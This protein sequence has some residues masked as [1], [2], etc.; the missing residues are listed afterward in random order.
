MGGCVT[1]SSKDRGSAE[2]DERKD[3]NQETTELHASQAS[4]SITTFKSTR[5][6]LAKFYLKFPRINKAYKH[7]FNGWCEAIGKTPSNVASAREIFNF[8]GPADKASEALSNVGIVASNNEVLTAL[9]EN[10]LTSPK[11]NSGIL[12]FKDLVIA[13]CYILKDGGD[14]LKRSEDD[15]KS[16]KFDEIVVG[17]KIVQDMFEQI[18]G[19]GS[20]EISMQEFTDAFADLSLG[21]DTG[22]CQKRMAELDFNND[23]EISYPEFCVGISVWVGFID[24]FD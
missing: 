13:I 18:D 8:E 7:I 16:V 15:A 9:S 11:Q 20:G 22:I 24:E 21:D 14:S 1:S 2:D 23:Q 5:T 10:N 6:D 19:D 12:R 17:L 4:Q 3:V